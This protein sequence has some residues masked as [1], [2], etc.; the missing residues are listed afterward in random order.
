MIRGESFPAGSLSRRR[1]VQLAG[2]SG[3]GILTGAGRLGASGEVES[4]A[5]AEGTWGRIEKLGEGIWAVASTPLAHDDWTTLCNG[6]IVAGE[7]R[8]LVIESFAGPEGAR[9]VAEQARQLCGRWPT[10]VIVTHYH[11][12]HANGFEGFADGDNRPA[13]WMTAETQKWI[14]NED[15]K[16]DPA[17]APLRRE[18]L[19][20]A[21]LLDPE[22][23]IH[24]Q[25]GGLDLTIH[26]RRGH[27]AS[28]VTVE[29][30]EPGV[31]FCGD[32][33]WNQMFPNFRD[34]LPSA[35]SASVRSLQRDSATD[36]V[37]GHGPLASAADVALFI[38][39]IDSVEIASRTA[40][41]KGNS[42]AQAAAGFS[43]SQ[44][45]RDWHLFRESY[46]EVAIGAW[47]KELG[48]DPM[49]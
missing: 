49:G 16:R 6:G 48:I 20:A 11:G 44:P 40:I 19:E 9:L 33:V 45:L 26:P 18:L 27:T 32:L 4:I 24:W 39:L 7:N 3:L 22:E 28:D 21:M 17:P 14:R 2:A 34:T 10:D 47:Y 36:Y 30:D 35:L 12:D 31:V 8:V 13:L 43:L 1:F 46:F 41:E 37:P 25:L 15:A 38:D 23:V 5:V 42:A 29:L